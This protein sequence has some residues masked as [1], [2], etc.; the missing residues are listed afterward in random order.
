MEVE[1]ERRLREEKERER[2]RREREEERQR[3]AKLERE[4]EQ[5]RKQEELK[6]AETESRILQQ[7]RL[8]KR[9]GYQD[10]PGYDIVKR[11][12]VHDIRSGNMR[13]AGGSGGVDLYDISSSVFSRLDPQKQAA[14]EARMSQ[15]GSGL[16]GVSGVIPGSSGGGKTT[17]SDTYGRR[18]VADSGGTSGSGG[19]RPSGYSVGGGGG[20]GRGREGVSYPIPTLNKGGQNSSQG[21][22]KPGTLGGGVSV[23]SKS[24]SLAG[25]SQDIISAALAIQ[26][27]VGPGSSVAS[28]MRM[29]GSSPIQ[30]SAHISPGGM[31]DFMNRGE[32]MGGQMPMGGVTRQMMG[33]GGGG[34]GPMV[35]GAAKLP[36]MEERYNRRFSRPPHAGRQ[37]NMKRF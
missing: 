3:I 6:W 29:A 23:V 15:L 11:Q 25:R 4:R 2:E 16:P 17:I 20:M 31:G 7:Q 27:T 5:K 30:Q 28:Q 19:Y 34:M 18:G 10:S 13:G 26:K 1:R 12:T 36:P 24:G 14:A 35:K 33:S 37:A 9:S 32:P 21:Y 8:G 22:Q